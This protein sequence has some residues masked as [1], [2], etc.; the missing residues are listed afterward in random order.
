VRAPRS[1]PATSCRRREG[2]PASGSRPT[3]GRPSRPARARRSF[4]TA[5]YSMIRSFTSEA[6][7]SR[8]DARADHRAG[9]RSGHL[10]TSSS[11]WG[12]RIQPYSGFCSRCAPAGRLLLACFW[13]PRHAGAAMRCG[14]P[15]PRPPGRPQS[16]WGS[17]PARA[18]EIALPLVCR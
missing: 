5:R 3:R 12:L 9:G 16:P 4:R 7:V 13:T 14:S 1:H 2:P 18:A 8:Q 15:R 6:G 11:Q 17:R 10:R